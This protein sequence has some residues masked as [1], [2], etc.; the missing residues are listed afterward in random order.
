[1]A[2][3][4]KVD[5]LNLNDVAR[6]AAEALLQAHPTVVFTSGRRSINDQARAMAGNVAQ[7]RKF[8]V[9]TYG[10][11][12]ERDELQKWVDD[13]PEANTSAAIAAG[14]EGVMN[15]WPAERQLRISRHLVG[16]AFDV[17]PVEQNAAAIIATIKSLPNLRKFIDKEGGLTR[18][19]ADFE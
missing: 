17:Q 1:M 9:Q 3:N 4:P 11:V 5:A 10:S 18:W 7:N 6:R 14:L 13:H 12:A 2:P 15:A 16:A 19:H 8:I